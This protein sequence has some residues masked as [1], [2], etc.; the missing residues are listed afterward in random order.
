MT[1]HF[2]LSSRRSQARLP[3]ATAFVWFLTSLWCCFASAQDSVP[4]AELPL[5]TT[6]GWVTNAT[7]SRD[8]IFAT[9]V[10]IPGANWL[11]IRFDA[12]H[13]GETHFGTPPQIRVSSVSD[14]GQQVLDDLSLRQWK[15]TTAYFNGEAVLVELIADPGAAP[16]RLD[17]GA[18]IYDG[19]N[20]LTTIC[21]AD[22][23]V[24]VTD[25]RVGRVLPVTCT[26]FLFDDT[27][28]CLLGA[29]HCGVPNATNVVQFNVPL[30][31]ASGAL[32]HPHPDDQ[33]AVDDTSIQRENQGTPGTDWAYFGCFPNSNTGLTPAA[34]QGGV[35]ELVPPPPVQ[36]QTLRLTGFGSVS[37]IQPP[38]WNFASKSDTGIYVSDGIVLQYQVDTTSGNSGSPVQLLGT[39]QVFG[40]HT[41]GGCTTASTGANQGTSSQQANLQAALSAA[42]GVCATG[43]LHFEWV[44]SAPDIFQPDGQLL[45]VAV[46]EDGVSLAPGT[47]RLHLNSGA[48][49]V[50]QLMT[51]VAP[52]TYQVTLPTFAC[53]VSL[54]FYFS[55]ETT[56]L[57]LFFF[58]AN[59]PVGSFAATVA[60]ALEPGFVDDFEFDQGW[61]VTGDAIDGQ[62]ER[63]VPV[64]G[65]DLGD[66]PLDADGSGSC[67]LTDN[68]EG[69]SD[70]DSGTTI[71]TSPILSLQQDSW[72]TYWRWFDSGGSLDDT[73]VAEVAPVGGAWIAIE[74]VV[75]ADPSASGGWVQC[76]F[77]MPDFVPQLGTVQVRFT[78]SDL[79][80][81]H[82]VE[83]GLDGFR[84]ARPTCPSPQIP[85]RRGDANGDSSVDVADAILL[86][87]ALFQGDSL[88]CAIAADTNDDEAFDLAD[89]IFVLGFLF[90]GGMTVIPAPG[91]SCGV[92]PTLGNLPCPTPP[93]C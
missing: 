81:D 32:V 37:P 20:A 26:A 74:S 27:H 59:A 85:M 23:R 18:V 14:A 66:P 75:G 65:G 64:G 25:P 63:G 12:V 33:Y 54:D 8:V 45:T 91:I 88:P 30:S 51:E 53:G 40:I 56:G 52:G 83:A 93:P 16:L 67:Y 90:D 77:R 50:E 48:G 2:R 17:L 61:T 24:P 79:G 46:V 55:A 4:H 84:L 41:H 21:G 39:S 71:L 10:E 86:L 49:Y 80:A 19:V 44:G 5:E 92:D 87:G 7:E 36:G 28:H 9:I 11:R 58:P 15:N 57:G 3:V 31:T 13:W 60:A 29:G 22:D 6:S 73:W 43:Q 1:Q 72:L 35:F 70:V 47:V 69:N 34:S 76:S 78:V 38:E 68:V 42:Q 89:A 82:A 62:W